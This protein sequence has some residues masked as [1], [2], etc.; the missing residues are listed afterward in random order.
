M[1]DRTMN[2]YEAAARSKKVAALVE[3]CVKHGIGSADLKEYDGMLWYRLDADV[4]VK[5]SSETTRA[6][7]IERLEAIEQDQRE[8]SK[9]LDAEQM[10]TGESRCPERE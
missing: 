2:T 9:R 7:V 1:I 4:E 5:K 10:E 8:E 6:L 3:Y